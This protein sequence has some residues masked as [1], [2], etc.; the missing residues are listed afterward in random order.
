MY[1]VEVESKKGPWAAGCLLLLNG[2]VKSG[3]LEGQVFFANF[4]L[5]VSRFASR[6]SPALPFVLYFVVK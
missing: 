4:L 2:L 6:V 1:G 3:K 5:A